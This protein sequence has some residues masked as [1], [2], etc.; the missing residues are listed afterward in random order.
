MA[1]WPTNPAN[2]YGTT[3][4]WR[5]DMVTLNGVAAIPEP[6]TYALMLAG[7]R[8]HR[9]PGP[10][11]ARLELAFRS[12]RRAGRDDADL[13]AAVAG[14]RRRFFRLLGLRHLEAL[15]GPGL[16]LRAAP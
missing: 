5:F 10:P 12:A 2:S 8:R 3:G 9:L 11:P 1:I 7:L 13:N 15:G 6:G 14:R 4:T 16:P